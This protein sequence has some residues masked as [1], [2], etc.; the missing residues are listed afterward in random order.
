[1]E[2]PIL[3]L[4]KRK[5]KFCKQSLQ[6]RGRKVLPLFLYTHP[7][8]KSRDCPRYNGDARNGVC[9]QHL[10]CGPYLSLSI[11]KSMIGYFS[12][13]EAIHSSPYFLK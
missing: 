13:Q 2:N 10:C 7:D 9:P 1:M 12:K 11:V 5:S 3:W 8:L 6:K 4:K